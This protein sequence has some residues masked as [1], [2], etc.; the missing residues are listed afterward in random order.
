M[1]S[2]VVTRK[3]RLEATGLGFGVAL[4]LAVSLLA[5]ATPISR[6]FSSSQFVS[7]DYSLA[8][9]DWLHESTALRPVLKA[10]S[11]R[12]S[13]RATADLAGWQFYLQRLAPE[14]SALSQTVDP[15]RGTDRGTPRLWPVL[16]ATVAPP[17]L[18]AYSPHAP[19][20]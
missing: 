10:P 7:P 16:P 9:A 2:V 17:T 11:H 3:P 19:P 20:V 4:L 15:R 14:I 8:A 5:A 12:P 1:L 6:S 13:Q 18:L